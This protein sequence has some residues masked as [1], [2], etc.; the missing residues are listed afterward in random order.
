[1]YFPFKQNFLKWVFF[2]NQKKIWQVPKQPLSKSRPIR[3]SCITCS[4]NGKTG[5]PPCRHSISR[6]SFSWIMILFRGRVCRVNAWSTRIQRTSV[7]LCVSIWIRTTRSSTRCTKCWLIL[8]TSLT[9]LSTK[10]RPI[11]DRSQS[12]LKNTFMC[13]IKIKNFFSVRL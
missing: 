6:S 3:L 12:S 4:S 2:S 5:K 1:M 11:W 13:K 10:R 9:F 7:S 8:R